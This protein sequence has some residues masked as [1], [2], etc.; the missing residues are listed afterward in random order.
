MFDKMHE[1][2]DHR[3]KDPGHCSGKKRWLHVHVSMLTA[4]KK[5][6]RFSQK[7]VSEFMWRILTVTNCETTE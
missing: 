7:L 6:C 5:F 1:C 2:I 3:L 4:I